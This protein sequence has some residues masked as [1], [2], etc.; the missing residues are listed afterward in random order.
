MI[1]NMKYDYLDVSKYVIKHGKTTLKVP[2][3]YCWE[4]EIF[5]GIGKVNIYIAHEDDPFLIEAESFKE[6]PVERMKC[7]NSLSKFMRY[8]TQGEPSVYEIE[9]R[10]L[11]EKFIVTKKQENKHAK[12]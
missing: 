10:Y 1:Y 8:H 5:T 7:P 3:K 4:K 9:Y 11:S 2:E 12:R 6:L